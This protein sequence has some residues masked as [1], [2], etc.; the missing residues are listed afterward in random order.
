M[1]VLLYGLMR[2]REVR[3]AMSQK[4]FL[5]VSGTIFGIIAVLHLL[6]ITYGWSAQ[7]GTFAVPAWVSWLSLVVAGYLSIT[8]FMLLRK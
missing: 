8:A 5:G 2:T 3:K 7:I 4:P 6:R 1:S